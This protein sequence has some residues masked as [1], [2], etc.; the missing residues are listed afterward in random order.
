MTVPTWGKWLLG[1]GGFVLLV[2]VVLLSIFVSKVAGAERTWTS[3]ATIEIAAPLEEVR[4]RIES[5]RRWAEW[6]AWVRDTDEG[7][8]REFSGPDAGEGAQLRWSGREQVNF[9]IGIRPTIE[10]GSNLKSTSK[11]GSGVLRIVSSSADRIEVETVFY[12]H[13]VFA[14]CAAPGRGASKFQFSRPGMD[15]PLRGVI[16]LSQRG[17][18]TDVAWEE[19]G[20][21][22]EGFAAGLLALSVRTMARE[23]HEELLKSSLRGLQSAAE[24]R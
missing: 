15:M 12:D 5:P 16:R 17:G 10:S 11:A 21:F 19:T 2:V 6:S 7:V 22:G 14:Q 13:A 23:H 3:S 4:A 18:W 1:C 20:D 8:V 9:R 24:G